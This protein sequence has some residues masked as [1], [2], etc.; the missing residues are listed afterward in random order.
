M[1]HFN[2]IGQSL[3]GYSDGVVVGGSRSYLSAEFQFSPEW[4]GLNKWA[5]FSVNGTTYDIQLTDDG[6]PKGSLDL[7]NGGKY[8]VW[9]HGTR[10]QDGEATARIV[11]TKC[12][13]TVQASPLTEGG[14]L[15]EITPSVAEQIL[16][17]YPYIDGVTKNWIIW[18]ADTQAW[19]DTGICAEGSTDYRDMHNKPS[20]N[21]VE[22]DGDKTSA[23][24]GIDRT[25]IHDQ[26]TASDTWTIQHN[27][28][29]YPSVTVVDS[30]G[31]ICEG[32]VTYMDT[33]TIVC[34]FNGAFSGKAYLN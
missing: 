18:D 33:N 12:S 1:L 24:L 26:S 31:T 16:G 5:H 19:K 4:D 34:N 8:A 28:G 21:G 14:P 7:E 32:T 25:Y 13:I 9:V 30:A 29:K 27:L 10:L 15:P 20:I 2:V 6:I 23:E 3:Q 11:T 22:L 17:R